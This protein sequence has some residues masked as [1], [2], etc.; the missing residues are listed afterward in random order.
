MT[1]PR[2]KILIG[3]LCRFAVIYGLLVAP[4]PGWKETC[5][6]YLRAIAQG[7]LARKH[8]QM[9]LTFEAYSN[10]PQTPDDTRVVIV[11]RNLM[12]PD[13]SGPVRNLDLE[14]GR[15][16]ANSAALLLAL[17]VSTPISWRRREWAM[18]VGLFLLHASILGLLQYL[19]WRESSEIGLVALSGTMK[20]VMAGF[21]EAWVRQLNVTVPVLIWVLTCVRREEW[22]SLF[23]RSPGNQAEDDRERV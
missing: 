4:W 2:R 14:L 16:G 20:G 18:L 23:G 10:R 8:G 11:N 5:A 6:R 12:A 22:V 17:I 3:F 21:G 15:I 13:G 9:E 1:V 7:A 19:I